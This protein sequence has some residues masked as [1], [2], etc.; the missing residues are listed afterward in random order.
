MTQDPLTP[1]TMDIHVYEVR[2]V[3]PNFEGRYFMTKC[4]HIHTGCQIHKLDWELTQKQMDD[5]VILRGLHFFKPIEDSITT[6]DEMVILHYLTEDED[7]SS[8]EV[9]Y[10]S[11]LRYY[12]DGEDKI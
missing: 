3:D 9:E 8:S 1:T 4:K 11:S 2:K 7:S 10:V 5:G 6:G 12:F